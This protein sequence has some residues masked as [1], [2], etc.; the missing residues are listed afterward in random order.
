MYM[1]DFDTYCIARKNPTRSEILLYLEEVD[2][3]C[4]KCGTPFSRTNNGRFI[5]GYE[6]AHVFPNS[7]TPKEKTMLQNVRIAGTNS[8]DPL[9]KI[10]LCHD[11]HKYYDDNKSIELYNEMFDLKA[12][13]HKAL[14]AKKLILNQNIEAELTQI[15]SKLAS[16]S[17]LEIDGLKKLEY[18]ALK[19]SDKIED[20]YKLLRRR[21]END[22]LEYFTFIR[23]EFASLPLESFRFDTMALNI[24]YA[25][26]KLRDKGLDKS[27]I[28][29]QMTNWFKRKTAC[30][31]EACSIMVSFFVQDCEIY[32]RLS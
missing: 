16:L 6:I 4:P 11:C 25:Y 24:K 5:K 10:A 3:C 20:T 32:E 13:K 26:C 8:E 7:P 1:V 22:V 14:E 30:D 28:Y 23:Q 21:I 19:V 17:D 9:N 29:W 15:I 12:E 18:K 31:V 2:S 27:E